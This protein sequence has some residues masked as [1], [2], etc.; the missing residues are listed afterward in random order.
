MKTIRIKIIKDFIIEGV[1]T[2]GFILC[3]TLLSLWIGCAVYVGL[4]AIYAA[5][6][7]KS[8]AGLFKKVFKK[9]KAVAE[10]QTGTGETVP[11]EE[12]SEADAIINET[13]EN[14]EDKR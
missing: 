9:K 12:E 6:N 11:F 2:V 13:V 4:F 1:L 14:E 5:I 3:A 8:I 10:S 7:Y